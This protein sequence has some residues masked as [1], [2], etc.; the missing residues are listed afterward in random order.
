MRV[1]TLQQYS[2]GLKGI[3][4][5]QEEVNK[6]QQQV[7]TGR[8]V[9]TPADDPIAA[10]KILQL[11]QDLALNEQYTRNMTAAENRL[12]LEEAT[13]SSVTENIARVKELTVQAGDGS[14]TIEDRQA[15]AAE[16]YQLQE[17][18]A[19]LFNTRDANGEHI[20]AGFKGATEPFQKTGT[21]R[22]E[23]VGDEG[24]RYLAIGATTTVATGDS[25]KGLFVDVE[26]AKNTFTT[27]LNPLNTGTLQVNP[28]FVVDE[29]AYA[30][31]YPDD[32]VI[33]FN[34]ESA[35]TPP[36]P[37]YT[38]R[39]ASD[40]R[41]V[42]GM[43]NETYFDGAPITVAGLS[44][45][46][47]GRPEPG[48]E[49]LARSSP[50]QSITDTLYRLTAGLNSLTDSPVDSETLDI[51]I[52]DTLTNLTNAQTSVSQKVS[53]LGA[54]LNVVENTGNLAADVKLVNQEVLSKL[55]DV[56]FAEA[57]SRLSLQTYLLEA[58]QQSYTTISRLSLFNQL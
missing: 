58:A 37:N 22:Y 36:G 27:S 33:T 26:A 50:K 52:E 54:R 12:N 14:Y 57:V 17:A 40:N 6:T 11:Q 41:V 2:T 3:L 46:M 38:V 21:G 45:G 48:D 42:D 53:E 31:F 49:I 56:D 5:N 30:E 51:L 15:I 39:R 44:I 4:N 7:S 19:D 32:L 29:E 55:S 28:G 24:Q 16:I 1:A 23:F 18:L 8:R 10:T 47:S 43:S 35:I 34:P 20:F 13:L 25:G 9:L